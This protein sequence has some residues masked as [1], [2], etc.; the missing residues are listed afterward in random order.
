MIN[1][2][3]KNCDKLSNHLSTGNESNQSTTASDFYPH[4][5]V[6]RLLPNPRRIAEV[7]V[8]NFILN[9]RKTNDITKIMLQ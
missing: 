6:K 7:S 1:C 4:D 2:E 5:G 3:R 8:T 9:S